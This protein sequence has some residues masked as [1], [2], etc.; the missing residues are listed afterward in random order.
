MIAGLIGRFKPLHNGAFYVM[1]Y[2]VNNYD[3]VRI[4]VGGSNKPLSIH[5][6][7]T[8]Q[9][10]K[11]M[12]ELAL[13]GY[14]N[15]SVHLIPDYGHIPKYR[16]GQM[17]KKHVLKEMKD[18]DHFYSGNKYVADLLKDEFKIIDPIKVSNLDVKGSLVRYKLALGEDVSDLVPKP[19]LDYLKSNNLITR[20]RENYGEETIK[21]YKNKNPSELESL[22]QE[23]LKI[24][25]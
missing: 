21:L 17:W 18:V 22:A 24:T 2:S 6:P 14:D 4:G 9:E 16:D 20:F 13:K 19:V 11:E 23:R 25:K 10:T 1:K 12:I 3:F 8:P 15:F 7:F 5:D